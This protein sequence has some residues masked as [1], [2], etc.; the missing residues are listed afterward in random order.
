[1]KYNSPLH[2]PHACTVS[3]PGPC[4]C[5]EAGNCWPSP[6]CHTVPVWPQPS[7]PSAPWGPPGARVLDQSPWETSLLLLEGREI[8]GSIK[9]QYI[10][11]EQR[12]VEAYTQLPLGSD[13]KNVQS[14]DVNTGS[15]WIWKASRWS[16]TPAATVEVLSPW[17]IA[18][19][20]W[21]VY[22]LVWEFIERRILLDQHTSLCSTSSLSTMYSTILSESVIYLSKKTETWK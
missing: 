4:H 5:R 12:I 1:M 7:P 6:S 9:H 15:V 19:S 18:D 3:R 2:R 13:C 14:P 10:V 20:F 8:R 17:K 22:S 21:N 16:Y 11:D